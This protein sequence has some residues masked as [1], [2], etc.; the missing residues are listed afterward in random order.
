MKYFLWHVIILTYE[1]N[2]RLEKHNIM[3]EKT[4]RYDAENWKRIDIIWN[5]GHKM[6]CCG[7]FDCRYSI[8]PIWHDLQYVYMSAI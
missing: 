3:H 4:V 1:F 5:T 2:S 8:Y 6:A 7:A